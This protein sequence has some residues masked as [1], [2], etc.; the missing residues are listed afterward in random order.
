MLCFSFSYGIVSTYVAIYGKEELGIT[1]R[2]GL[3]FSLF[4][5]GLIVSRLT[6][7]HALRKGQISRNAAIGVLIALCGYLIFAAVHNAIGY[8]CSAF[9][10]GLGNGHMYPAFQNMFINLAPHNQR[11][12]ANSS[13]LTS[14]DAGVGLGILLG[15]LLA[16]HAG[17]HSAFWAA[18][19]ANAFGVL[20]YFL[21]I[22][23]HFE[24]SRLR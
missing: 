12:T 15:G 23:R 18:G 1:G 9:I 8:F 3:F 6:G 10:I 22:R 20:F 21:V 7:A 24:T 19:L 4:A 13:I 2:T 14:W 16:E 5:I 11:G 17:Y